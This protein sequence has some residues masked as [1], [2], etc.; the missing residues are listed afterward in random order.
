[1]YNYTIMLKYVKLIKCVI[2]NNKK[3]KKQNINLFATFPYMYL[4]IVCLYFVHKYVALKLHITHSR[5][6][7]VL[8]L[9]PPFSLSGVLCD[10]TDLIWRKVTPF[11]TMTGRT[12]SSSDGL[13]TEVFWGFP[14]L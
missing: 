10:P 14:R 9:I 13:L 4:V 6:H 3:F 2:L 8:S 11:E 7:P 5:S 1:M 12:A